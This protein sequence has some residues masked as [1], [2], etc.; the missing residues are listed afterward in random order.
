MEDWKYDISFSHV[1]PVRLICACEVDAC[2][3]IHCF[4]FASSRA[5]SS[6]VP[7]QEHIVAW[8]ELG[9]STISITRM[10]PPPQVSVRRGVLLINFMVH[11]ASQSLKT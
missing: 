8:L 10:L 5:R 6:R 9:G 2:S 7:P 3:T 1:L 4:D 11:T